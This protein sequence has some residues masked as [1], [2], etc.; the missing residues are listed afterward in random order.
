[1][2]TDI[3]FN[4]SNAMYSLMKTITNTLDNYLVN[5]KQMWALTLNIIHSSHV[6]NILH[7]SSMLSDH[8]ATETYMNVYNNQHTSPYLVH[9]HILYTHI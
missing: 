6:A 9:H 3:A 4:L 1:M 8:G 5:H 7:A 2:S